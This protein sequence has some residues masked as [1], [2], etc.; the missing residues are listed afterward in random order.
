MEV[1]TYAPMK[2]GLK[3]FCRVSQS[4]LDVRS[5][6][7]P[8]EKGTER[9][10]RRRQRRIEAVATYAPMKRGLK[11]SPLRRSIFLRV[12]SNLCP[13]EKGTERTITNFRLETAKQ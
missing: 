3:V 5:N 6:L 7:C 13:D 4:L 9:S 1:A 12:S 8:D 10:A 2:R 11:D